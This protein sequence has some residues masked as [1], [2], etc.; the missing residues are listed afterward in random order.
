MCNIIHFTTQKKAED[1]EGSP[2]CQQLSDGRYGMTSNV[3]MSYT[4][5]VSGILVSLKAKSLSFLPA[6]D[7]FRSF[8]RGDLTL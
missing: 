3:I 7:L 1:E 5:S 8:S 2:I 4:E 6:S